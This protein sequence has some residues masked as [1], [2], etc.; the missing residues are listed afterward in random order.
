MCVMEHDVEKGLKGERSV[1]LS[2]LTTPQDL[3][4]WNVSSGGEF[5]LRIVWRLQM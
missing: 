5:A 3:S 2:F 4:C 1:P